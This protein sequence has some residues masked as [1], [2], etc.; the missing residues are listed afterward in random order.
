MRTRLYCITNRT[1]G[2]QYVGI[3]TKSV[4][5][6]WRQHVAASSAMKCRFGAAIQQYGAGDFEAIELHCYDTTAQAAVAEI[7]VIAHLDL[8]NTGWN[9]APGG[10]VPPSA[11]GLKRSAAT[12]A[13]IAAVKT[14]HSVS[15]SSRAKMAASK[16]GCRLSL[17]HRHN[18]AKGQLGRPKTSGF[19]GF[20]HTPEA[21]EAIAAAR[22]LAETKRAALQASH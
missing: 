14:G 17:S 15:E 20:H 18:I 16:T 22:R 2:K 1:T 8:M 5:E 19:A 21:R 13:K 3:T 6:R 11:L 12:C 7:A 10:E 4:A 9:S